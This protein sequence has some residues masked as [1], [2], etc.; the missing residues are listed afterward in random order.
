MRISSL[1][2]PTPVCLTL[3]FSARQFS[4]EG[5]LHLPADPQCT[6][7]V[8]G[9]LTSSVKD[10]L[11]QQVKCMDHLHTFSCSRRDFLL[12]FTSD[13][14]KEGKIQTQGYT[15]NNFNT[16]HCVSCKIQLVYLI[17]EHEI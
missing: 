11:I 13:Y 14:R 17:K 15:R 4:I 6:R 7:C 2:P 16:D 12:V 1:L 10:L 5:T 8:A 3:Q 9:G